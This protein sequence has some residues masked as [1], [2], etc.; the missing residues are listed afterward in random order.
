MSNVMRNYRK[1]T[2][3]RNDAPP[4]E[5]HLHIP[6]VSNTETPLAK[7]KLIAEWK[8]T[9]NWDRFFGQLYEYYNGGGMFPIL[10]ARIMN[11]LTVAFVLGFGT[12]LIAC[13]DHENISKRR[14]L[15]DAL[16]PQCMAKLHSLHVVA[17]L[18]FSSYWLYE[19]VRIV[20]DYP[21]L[22]RMR[23]FVNEILGVS[24]NE[25]SAVGWDQII[26]KVVALHGEIYPN[27]GL[28]LPPRIN[29]SDVASRI[30]R[31]ENYLIALFNKDILNLRPPFP[32]LLTFGFGGK[33][34]LTKVLEWNLTI[35]VMNYAFGETD[36]G[37]E[38]GVRKEFLT[39]R[40][41][42]RL[43][44]GLKKRFILMG[45]LN[46]LLS[47]F[48]LIFLCVYFLFKYG[49]EF[50]KDP[51]QLGSRSYSPIARWKFRD[52]NELPH[53]FTS[54]LNASYPL[55]EKYVSQFHKKSVAI[56]A[57]FISFVAGSV[58]LSLTVLSILDDD[59]LLSFYISE[60]RTV[61]WYLGVFGIIWST[62]RSMVPDSRMVFEP[63]R[64]LLEVVSVTHYL[65]IS[66]KNSG[67]DSEFVHKEFSNLFEMKIVLFVQEMLSIL[68]APF[69][70]IFSLPQCASAIVD[71]FREFT[72]HVDGVGWVCT[73]S[74][75]DF[76]RLDGDHGKAKTRAHIDM[77]EK[78]EQSVLNFKSHHPAWKPAGQQNDTET[79]LGHELESNYAPSQTHDVQSPVM[80]N[81]LKQS[82]YTNTA[83]ED[84]NSNYYSNYD[85][86]RRVDDFYEPPSLDDVRINY[87][88]PFMNTSIKTENSDAI[89]L[90]ERSISLP[91][92]STSKNPHPY[93]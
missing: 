37:E 84:R 4:S 34:M 19:L 57:Q 42:N 79:D 73:F 13:V 36:Q 80:S 74:V 72:V 75:F 26:Q 27:S 59:I 49:Q 70:L 78:L 86:K 92:Q 46:L 54:R 64:L 52:F 90:Q 30:M 41:R 56:I 51:S 66:W 45:L 35:C 91:P 29:A 60:G 53:V 3:I 10:L 43:I 55:A 76:R 39:D 31:K 6:N 67:L 9:R 17:L 58:A 50:H 33:Q 2:D 11:L 20:L 68:L 14:T 71:F 5:E 25:L 23:L 83:T 82:A 63:E 38:I 15:Q 93:N 44:A 61:L 28:S 77:E 89:E 32:A 16:V 7:A 40:H 24:D 47:P 18:M 1:L 62:A 88:S 21:H 8:S 65:P 85:Y 87:A 12:F 22:D 69:V 48:I 81:N